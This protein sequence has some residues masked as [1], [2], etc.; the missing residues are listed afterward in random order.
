MSEVLLTTL[1]LTRL[2]GGLAAVSGVAIE[3]ERGKLHAV[4]GPNGAGKTTVFNLLT[5]FL[6]PTAGTIKIPAQEL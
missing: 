4:L 1:G 3:L 2:F 6:P 5:K